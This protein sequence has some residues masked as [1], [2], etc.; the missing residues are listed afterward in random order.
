MR[1]RALTVESRNFLAKLLRL[2]MN[3]NLYIHS[4]ENLISRC[5]VYL[6]L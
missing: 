1:A 3:L 5:R 2:L 4:V 6:L